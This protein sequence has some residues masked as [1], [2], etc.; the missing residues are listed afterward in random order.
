VRVEVER[1]ERGEP[2]EHDRVEEE[3]L[4]RRQHTPWP[5]ELLHVEGMLEGDR[6]QQLDE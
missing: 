2:R 6:V 4:Q 1:H 3:G 5:V